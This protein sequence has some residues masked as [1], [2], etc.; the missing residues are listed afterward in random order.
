MLRVCLDQFWAELRV[1]LWQLLESLIFKIQQTMIDVKMNHFE[2]SNIWILRKFLVNFDI[3]K[4][5]NFHRSFFSGL[6]R[7]GGGLNGGDLRYHYVIMFQIGILLR[8]L[9]IYYRSWNLWMLRRPGPLKNSP[10][11]LL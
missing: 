1:M 11:S 10:S 4:P 3:F 7:F 2:Y 9:L 8:V 6:P 5:E